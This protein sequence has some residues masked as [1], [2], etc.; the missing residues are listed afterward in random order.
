MAVVI[1]SASD[2]EAERL[3][4]SLGHQHVDEADHCYEL[5]ALG[6]RG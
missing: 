6:D 1:Q 3:S 2:D 4:E 5:T